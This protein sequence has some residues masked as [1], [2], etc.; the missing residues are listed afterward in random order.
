MSKEDIFI[1]GKIEVYKT[2]LKNYG[3][4]IKQ[5]ISGETLDL[6][7]STLA[8]TND[9]F[10]KWFFKALIKDSKDLLA[11]PIYKEYI[12]QKESNLKIE[13][14]EYRK[15]EKKGELIQH[16][17][18]KLSLDRESLSES[19]KKELLI[20]MFLTLKN[21]ESSFALFTRESNLVASMPLEIKNGSELKYFTIKEMIP[22]PNAK[23]IEEKTGVKPKEKSVDEILAPLVEG[24]TIGPAD[25]LPLPSDETW[26]EDENA[27][28][29]LQNLPKPSND[30]D[31]LQDF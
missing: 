16:W 15:L 26:I 10:A 30:A 11:S 3:T 29:T 31:W 9:N 8:K 1:I 19:F 4:A 5:P 14:I 7:R 17:V 23:E 28:P 21:I 12:L 18:S 2:F 24:Q 25:A 22:R 27:P 20:K 6:L 13:K